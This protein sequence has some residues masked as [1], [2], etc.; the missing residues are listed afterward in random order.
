M[1]NY[2]VISLKCLG[3]IPARYASTRFPGKSLALIAGQSMISRVYA[4]AKAARALADVVVA[5]DDERI[6]RHVRD[7]GGNVVYTDA[8]HTSGTDRVAEVAEKAADFDVIINIQG[9]EPLLDP[10]QLDELCNVFV[11]KPEVNIATFRKQIERLEEIENP[12]VVKVVTDAQGYAL[13][14]SRAAVPFARTGA[15]DYYKHIGLYAFRRETLLQVA[16][17]RTSALEEA[18][19]LEQLR[20]LENG[21]RI[22]TLETQTE[23][24]AVDTPEDVAA[25]EAAL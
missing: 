16:R 17:L 8:K 18:E 13:Y 1:E 4:R 24:L 11:E 5:T 14:F 2:S 22:F 10:A 25:V 20:W 19:S 6:F 21:Y 3:V 15:P 7:F 12:N 9:D 23:T